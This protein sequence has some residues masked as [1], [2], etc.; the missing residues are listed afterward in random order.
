VSSLDLLEERGLPYVFTDRHA[1]LNTA[2]FFRDR[3]K[4]QQVDFELLGRRDFQRDPEDPG[5]LE[6]YQA[7]VLVHGPMPVSGL[8]GLACYTETVKG[9]IQAECSCL[10]LEL[11]IAVRSH[12]YFR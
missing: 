7:E 10:D 2:R 11:P 1:Y 4:L 12:W 8:L 5:K 9:E 6:R 3:A